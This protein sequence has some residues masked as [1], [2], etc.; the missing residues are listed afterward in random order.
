MTKYETS[1]P[2]AL[3]VAKKTWATPEI[4]DQSIKSATTKGKLGN[5]TETPSSAGTAS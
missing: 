2:A 1:D 4:R 5:P 3:P